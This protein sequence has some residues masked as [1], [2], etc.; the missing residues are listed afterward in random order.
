VSFKEVLHLLNSY[1]TRVCGV[2]LL[3]GGCYLLFVAIRYIDENLIKAILAS[4][5]I[6]SVY[7]GVKY[8][9]E[10]KNMTK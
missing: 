7:M 4:V 3:A 5:G 9:R 2:I 10:S 6:F 8:L 1:F